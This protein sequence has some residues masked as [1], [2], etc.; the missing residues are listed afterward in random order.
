MNETSVLDRIGCDVWF[1]RV[2]STESKGVGQ[3]LRC[4]VR[5]ESG[6]SNLSVG[7]YG[8]GLVRVVFF[9][10]PR[11]FRKFEPVEHYCYRTFARTLHRTEQGEGRKSDSV[12]WL[13]TPN[14]TLEPALNARFFW[15]NRLKTARVRSLI[16]CSAFL[17]NVLSVSVEPRAP[18]GNILCGC[19]RYG[20]PPP[21]RGYEGL[22]SENDFYT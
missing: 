1:Q 18:P 9:D 3:Q 2:Y 13:R 4:W 12:L 7:C 8:F 15:Q 6:R 19:G 22:P 21:K 11:C 5:P 16:S 20:T 10:F 14:K 17:V